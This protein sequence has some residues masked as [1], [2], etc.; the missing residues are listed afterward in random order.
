MGRVNNWNV[1]IDCALLFAFATV[2]EDVIN[3]SEIDVHT[4]I[5]PQHDALFHQLVFSAVHAHGHGIGTLDFSPRTFCLF[6]IS[7]RLDFDL[8]ALLI[9][10]VILFKRLTNDVAYTWISKALICNRDALSNSRPHDA[11]AKY[12]GAFG[13]LFSALEVT[14]S[15]LSSE[16]LTF[17]NSKNIKYYKCGRSVERLSHEG[18]AYSIVFNDT[19]SPQSVEGGVEKGGM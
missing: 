14:N 16:G 8:Q 10:L 18:A 13:M 9:R 15:C 7:F 2:I 17:H 3:H 6:Y 4:Y 5:V 11:A 12:F 19:R 1:N